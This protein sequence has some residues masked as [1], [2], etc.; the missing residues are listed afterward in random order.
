MVLSPRVVRPLATTGF[1]PRRLAGLSAWYDATISSSLVLNSGS[2]EQWRDS[3]GYSQHL[4][5]A[6]AGSR[7]AVGTLSGKPAVAFDGTDDFLSRATAPSGWNSGTI[8]CVHQRTGGTESQN[9]YGLTA[10]SVIADR[11]MY[12]SIDGAT[13]EYRSGASAGGFQ[14][15]SIAPTDTGAVQLIT[16]TSNNNDIFGLRLNSVAATGSAAGLANEAEGIFLGCRSRDSTGQES[17]F[18]GTVGEFIVY[19]RVLSDAEIAAVE[20]YLRNKWQALIGVDWRFVGL[21]YWPAYQANIQQ[22]ITTATVADTLTTP[23]GTY[24]FTGFAGGVLLPD[25]RV[26]CVPFSSTTAFIYDPASDTLTV[27]SGTY[28][29]GGAFFGGVLLPNG[30]VFCVPRNSTTAFIYDPATDTLTVPSGTYPGNAAYS[31][32]VLLPDGRVFCVP[33]N[34]TTAR[35]YDPASDSLATP[36]GTYP[37]GS[38]YFGGVLLPDGRVFC[39]P[40]NATTARIYDPATDTVTTPSGI[41]PGEGAFFGGALLPDGRVFCV[42]FNSTT[43]RIYDPVADTLTTPSGTYPGG[44]AFLGGVLL[45]NGRVFCVPR[46]ATTARIYDPISNTLATPS[47]TYPGG[48]AFHNG[49]LL[50]D[51][52]AFCVPYNSTTARIYGGGGGFNINVIL[53]AYYN[54]L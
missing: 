46:S 42:P 8:F 17:F 37:G 26:F 36:S 34:N 30:R 19:N 52:R 3:S 22:T 33:H 32:G 44:S 12:V 49:V 5:Q 7:P 43:A 4:S 11:T 13:G 6:T 1:N 31:G 40:R 25:G 35:I 18:T 41:Y 23:S 53:S 24:P 10:P 38:A 9:L 29:S 45:P 2:V 15:R 39:V 21:S 28:P 54:K 14:N 47:G 27:P 50:S 51:G 48:L 16:Q 20:Q